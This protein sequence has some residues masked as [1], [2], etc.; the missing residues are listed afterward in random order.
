MSVRKNPSG[1]AP[2]DSS[3]RI[4]GAAKRPAVATTD[5]S[6]AATP[7]STGI[8]SPLVSP[9]AAR[10]PP[11]SA[12]HGPSS[13]EL[14]QVAIAAVQAGGAVLV[15]GLQRPL[16][17]TNKSEKA[18]IVTQVDLDS[19]A[20]VFATIGAAFPDHTI[21]GEEGDGGGTNSTYT[22]LV[23]PLDGT[24]NYAHGI[25]FSCVS[26][27]VRDQHGVVAGAIFEPFR[28]ELFSATRGGGAWLGSQRLQVSQT[29]A[30]ARALICTGLQSDDPA[31]IAAHGKR[32]MALHT[33]SRGARLLGSPALCLAY[34]AAGRIDAFFERNATYAWDVGA[35]SLLIIEAGGSCEDLDGGPLNLG[36]GIANVIG[37][38]GHLHRELFDLIAAT[39]ASA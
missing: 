22:W 29:P 5:Q 18:S 10:R 23:D 30:I 4:V 1:S 2:R 11:A 32:V 33:H 16:E 21:L 24:S 35:G 3:G 36:H 13:K 17:V 27:A 20:A 34:I 19:Q 12:D 8:T 26:V 28:G 14:L 25:P 38:N 15:T 39:D 31:D 9:A 37:S 6:A 7:R